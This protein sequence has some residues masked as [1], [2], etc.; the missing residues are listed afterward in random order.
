M[1]FLKSGYLG[2]AGN[3]GLWGL[4]DVGNALPLDLDDGYLSI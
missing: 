1:N 4:L 2:G 3:E